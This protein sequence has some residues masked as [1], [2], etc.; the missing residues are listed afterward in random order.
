M[1][2]ITT[3]KSPYY[4][5]WLNL[6]S[7]AFGIVVSP[8]I[9]ACIALVRGA[10]PSPKHLVIS[11]MFGIIIS[12]CIANSI[13]FLGLFS[14]RR[15]NYGWLFL[16][17]YYGVSLCGMFIGVELTYL[18]V[19]W[20]FGH[21]Y[22]FFHPDDLQFNT[23]IILIICTALYIYFSMKERQAAVIQ[24]KEMDVVRLEKLKT[25]AELAALQSKIN[26]HFLYN[27]LNSIAS[28]IT[29]DPAKAEEMTVK[30][31][32]L[33]RQSI[34]QDHG[35]WNTVTSEMDIVTTYLD[36]ERV[37]FGERIWFSVQVAEGLENARI[38]RFLLQPLVE[39]ALK[40]GLKDITNNGIL[41]IRI[42][43]EGDRLALVVADNG[44]PF[45]EELQVGHGLQSTYSKLQLLYDE[46]YQVNLQNAPD[47]QLTIHIP[48][49]A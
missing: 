15:A 13:Y 40:H 17:L 26:P 12:L 7:I 48:F 47:K 3:K 49:D 16:L 43:R 35:H 4:W 36:I 8:V 32:R 38:P 21:P 23:I 5:I 33:F 42:R 27:A 31:S 19:S 45:P 28:L 25:E 37:R 11:L 18:T 9:S 14:K 6:S 34:N 10:L 29:I 39:N 41:E 22:H 46:D 2:A 20:F 30:L 24:Q 44:T 1:K